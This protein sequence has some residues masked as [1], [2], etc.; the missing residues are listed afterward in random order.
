MNLKFNGEWRIGKLAD[1]YPAI[2]GVTG[3]HSVEFQIETVVNPNDLRLTIDAVNP[4]IL[5]I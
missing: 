3:E 2:E 5:N 1:Y 4:D